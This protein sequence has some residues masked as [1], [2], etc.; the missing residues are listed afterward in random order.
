M[1][2]V[3]YQFGIG[4]SYGLLVGGAPGFFLAA[5]AGNRAMGCYCA[6]A[7]VFGL[8]GVLLPWG[9]EEEDAPDESIVAL[10]VEDWV[11]LND[12]RVDIA[13]QRLEL[14]LAHGVVNRKLC[15]VEDM[16]VKQYPGQRRSVSDGRV[17]RIGYPGC[18]LSDSTRISE[19]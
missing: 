10:L 16:L 18:K 9:E 8:F 7:I 12:Q 6:V 11:A 4:G 14:G 2:N 3:Y 19:S 15:I 13:C 1:K 5:L 17:V